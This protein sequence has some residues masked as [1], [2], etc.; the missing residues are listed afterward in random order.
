MKISMVNPTMSANFNVQR[1]SLIS[2]TTTTTTTS[3]AVGFNWCKI[4]RKVE[5]QR[6]SFVAGW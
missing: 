6:R 2:V 1:G 5:R 4:L 3:E